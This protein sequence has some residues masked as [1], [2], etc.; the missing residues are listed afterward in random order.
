MYVF[1]S[2]YILYIHSQL[3]DHSSAIASSGEV[4]L[5]SRPSLLLSPPSPVSLW[6][7]SKAREI[8]FFFFFFPPCDYF[9]YIILPYCL[10]K[11][12]E[13]RFW[14]HYC[15]PLYSENI[16]QS[17]HIVCTWVSLLNEKKKKDPIKA[18]TVR[19]EMEAV[20]LS[21]RKLTIF[22]SAQTLNS[23]AQSF[24]SRNFCLSVLWFWQNQIS[25][26]LEPRFS[27]HYDGMNDGFNVD[28]TI[29]LIE[30]G[31]HFFFP[32]PFCLVQ[33]WQ[34]DM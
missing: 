9:I 2:V 20:L 7:W 27:Q 24:K 16:V 26:C 3:S 33:N 23:K 13:S 32:E 31:M 28:Y 22:K 30:A 1:L 10:C 21:R 5:T 25:W 29:H 4:F 19:S 14:I 18:I 11:L 15:S 8:C 17:W 6:P 12:L 34:S